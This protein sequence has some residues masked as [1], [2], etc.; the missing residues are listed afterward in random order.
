[1][2][3]R[4]VGNGLGHLRDDRAMRAHKW[5]PQDLVVGRRRADDQ[6]VAVFSHPPHLV[7]LADVDEDVGIGQSKPQDAG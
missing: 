3:D 6:A 4:R 7:D 1:M 5:I 2:P